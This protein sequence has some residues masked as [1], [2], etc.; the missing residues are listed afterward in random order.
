MAWP[1]RLGIRCNTGRDGL[2]SPRAA[3]AGRATAV[4]ALA[5]LGVLVGVQGGGRGRR[6]CRCGDIRPP[7]HDEHEQGHLPKPADNYVR[8]AGVDLADHRDWFRSVRHGTARTRIPTML[9]I[10]GKMARV[11]RPAHFGEFENFANCVSSGTRVNRSQASLLRSNSAR[12]SDAELS[13][14]ASPAPR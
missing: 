6:D 8:I 3:A 5:I 4:A 10:G 7:R 13:R 14:C 9:M 12:R 2:R 11:N 1:G